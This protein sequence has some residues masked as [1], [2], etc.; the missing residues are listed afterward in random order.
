MTF[1]ALCVAL[2]AFAL[3]ACTEN[4]APG[5][6]PAL[7]RKDAG[8]SAARLARLEAVLQEEVDAGL[9]AGFVAAVGHN[10][11]EVYSVA[12]GLAD[13]E[14]EIAM[15]Q[16]TRFRIASM[17]KPVVSFALMQ[18]VEEGKVLLTD[19]VSRYI[20]SF[21]QMR[22]AT[23]TAAGPNGSIP[24]EPLNRA[25]TVHDLMTH[26]SGIGYLFDFESDLGKLYL[27]NS[28]YNLDGD[29][30]ARID[31]LT[32]LPLY[33]QPGK[34]WIYSYSTD[35]V[36]RIIEVASGKSLEDYL[37][38]RVFA[39]LGMND[40]E[41][42][43]DESD[44]DRLAVVYAFG[45][46]GEMVKA[47]A[48][49]ALPSPNEKGHGWHSGGGGLVSTARDYLRF[50]MMLTQGGELDGVRLASPATVR[51]MLENHT[52]AE[53]MFEPWRSQNIGFGLGGSV[54]VSPGLTGNV[55]APGQWGWGGYYD[56]TFFI[57]PAD[58]LAVV[59]MAQREPGPTAPPSRASDLA[60]SIAYGALQ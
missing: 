5:P 16:T 15:A 35:V 28:L 56:T 22:V 59:L 20:P 24:T 58:N 33:D 32:A 23:S 25:I 57:S 27:R 31:A 39:P 48:G 21:A 11:R 44:F 47:Q 43:F 53:A 17:T 30:A 54:I 9:R 34:K 52:P 29:L 14:E 2:A 38:G 18:L 12:V 26:M 60:R 42:F 46:E 3:H 19:P 4:A 45:V 1:R 10:G 36:G 50:A 7:A 51:L 40:T 37:K 55:A 6:H 49:G 8:I 41:F 13:I